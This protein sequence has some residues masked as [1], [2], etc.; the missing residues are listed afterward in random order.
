MKIVNRKV[1]ELISA[2]Y[3]PRQL[4]GKQFED[5][6]SSLQRFG[7]VDPIIVNK[8][9]ERMDI[10][11]GGHQRLVVA[12]DIGMAEVPTVE[13]SLSLAKEKELNIRLNKNSGEWDWD[14]LANN[15]ESEE[16]LEWGFEEGDLLDFNG[17]FPSDIQPNLIGESGEKIQVVVIFETEEDKK[18]FADSIHWEGVT[19]A[20]YII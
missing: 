16:L 1:S 17:D 6:R 9:K 13:V 10:V 20:K 5:L 12:S 15:F 8:H 14:L 3:N 4:T 19:C 11:V 18:E 2:E 7:F